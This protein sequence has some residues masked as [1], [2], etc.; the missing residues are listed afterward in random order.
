MTQHTFESSTIQ[1]SKIFEALAL[2]H[3]TGYPILII[4]THGTAKT[5]AVL[6]YASGFSK[7]KSFKIEL[8]EGSRIGELTGYIDMNKLVN[9]KIEQYITPIAEAD[10][11]VIN[12]VDKGNSAIRN[13]MLGM[14]A[15]KMIMRGMNEIQLPYKLFVATCNTID[16]N[17]E[18]KPF[19]D[20]FILKI[21]SPRLTQTEIMQ[22]GLALKSQVMTFDIPDA[23]EI[24]MKSLDIKQ[25]V[26]DKFISIMY[27]SCSDRT[28]FKS[29]NMIA[30]AMLIWNLSDVEAVIKVAGFINP[31]VIPKITQ[32][33]M[34]DDL[35]VHKTHIESL[36]KNSKDISFL[37]AQL[38]TYASSIDSIK[39]LSQ[40]NRKRLS[41]YVLEKR[42]ELTKQH[43]KV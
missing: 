34:S 29:V 3:A 28:L 32:L 22:S 18:D 40:L 37:I 6:E 35:S 16:D 39:E 5:K 33:L 41:D 24:A 15:E 14:M 12:E 20:R 36:I 9:E 23:S 17:E 27:D 30:A 42:N 21:A 4:G 25:E 7:N 8:S 2:C 19:W 11:V 38:D 13:C 26:I 10:C 43:I 1:K 31:E